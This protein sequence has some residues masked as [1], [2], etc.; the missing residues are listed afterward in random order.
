M[1]VQRLK[2]AEKN[3]HDRAIRYYSILSAINDLKLTEREIQLIAF[4]SIHGNISYSTN[5][6]D[7][8]KMYDSST[9]TINNISSKLKKMGILVKDGS[10][11]KVNPVI[12]LDFNNDVVLEVKLVNGNS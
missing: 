1:I 4:T 7:F 5:K 3:A 2:K 12:M 6:E 10:K 8:C 9:A 11:M